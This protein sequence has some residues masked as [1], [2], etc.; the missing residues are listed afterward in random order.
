MESGKRQ[1]NLRYSPPRHDKVATATLIARYPEEFSYEN[2]D[3]LL[4]AIDSKLLPL[5]V[6]R[7]SKAILF[8][9][10]QSLC[11]N[12]S[13]GSS[14]YQVCFAVVHVILY[15]DIPRI[16]INDSDVGF[17]SHPPRYRRPQF[18]IELST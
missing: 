15:T 7:F 4:W 2:I 12:P 5:I 16:S 18:N 17:S 13:F 8:I 9:L 1:L 14:L 6:L 3:L 10:A 11:I